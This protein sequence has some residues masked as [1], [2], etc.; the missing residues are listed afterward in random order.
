[1]LKEKNLNTSSSES[2]S[3]K[4]AKKDFTQN[5]NIPRTSRQG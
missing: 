2:K 4:I 1:M 5:A 3:F